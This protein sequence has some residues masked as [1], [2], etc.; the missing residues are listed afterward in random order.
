MIR[1]VTFGYLI[2]MM[3]SCLLLV[4][5]SDN[6][7]YLMNDGVSQVTR[8]WQR[9]SANKP[10]TLEQASSHETAIK[11]ATSATDHSVAG[12]RTTGLLGHERISSACLSTLQR[13]CTVLIIAS[14]VA[15]P[16]D[17]QF[18]LVCWA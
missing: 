15:Q 8:H 17:R 6:I 1:H 9:K 18:R 16:S 2:C 10:E 14:H 3:S 4:I 7:D 11:A 5:V 13:E 12:N